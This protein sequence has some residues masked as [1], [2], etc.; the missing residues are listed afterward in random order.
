MGTSLFNRTTHRDPSRFV[1]RA[2]MHDH[3]ALIEAFPLFPAS[4]MM[5]RVIGFLDH[6][7]G[8][9]VDAQVDQLVRDIN[10]SIA[11]ADTFI[12]TMDQEPA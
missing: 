9:E 4:V 8:I 12:Q 11:E 1:L 6:C 2:N 7:V 10:R 5:H 3:R